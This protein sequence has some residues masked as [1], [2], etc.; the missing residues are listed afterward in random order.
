MKISNPVGKK[1]EDIATNFLKKKGYKILERN[2]RKSYGEIDIIAI[3]KKILVF[4]EVKTRT[5]DLFGKPEEQISTSK[6]RSLIKTAEF[7]KSSHSSLPD[8]MRIDLISVILD[9]NENESN[10]KHIENISS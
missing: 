10:I 3:H 9:N 5:T 4:V 1:G 6:L 2:Y 8:S 7:Y